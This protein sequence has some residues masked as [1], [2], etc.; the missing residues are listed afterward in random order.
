MALMGEA[1]NVG[2]RVYVSGQTNTA[3]VVFQ[4]LGV[5]F[6]FSLSVSAKTVI[7]A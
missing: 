2:E 4:T 3:L 7:L 6:S 1:G 5:C